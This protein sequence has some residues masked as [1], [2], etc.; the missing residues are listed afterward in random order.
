MDVDALDI[1][2]TI[3]GVR[4][5]GLLSLQELKGLTGRQHDLEDPALL[6]DP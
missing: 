5:A 2:V 4:V 3:S 6:G 1:R